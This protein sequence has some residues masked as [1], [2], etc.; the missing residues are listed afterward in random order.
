MHHRKALIELKVQKVKNDNRNPYDAFRDR[1]IFPIRDEYGAMNGFG[2]RI[3]DT[4]DKKPVKYVNKETGEVEIY[5]I[6]KYIN[7][8]DS[9][10]F[11]K[12]TPYTECTWLKN[13]SGN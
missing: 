9:V 1:I 8:N 7:S 5:E 12:S 6:S 10:L 11:R 3:M 13:P 4:H 2:G